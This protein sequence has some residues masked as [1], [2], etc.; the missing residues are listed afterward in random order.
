MRKKRNIEDII[1][2]V[3]SIFDRYKW[4]DDIEIELEDAGFKFWANTII[5][6]EKYNRDEEIW[7]YDVGVPNGQVLVLINWI[8]GF[9]WIYKKV[10]RG[11]IG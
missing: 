8:D 4:R 7:A 6:D 3:K 2:T 10:E 11:R 1:D 5:E 9:Y